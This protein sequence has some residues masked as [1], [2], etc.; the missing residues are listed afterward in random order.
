MLHTLTREDIT[1]NVTLGEQH[2][3][4]EE[5]VRTYLWKDSGGRRKSRYKGSE[6]EVYLTLKIPAVDEARG[7]NTRIRALGC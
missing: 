7:G 6:A 3:E 4:V 5:Q 2:K 1:E